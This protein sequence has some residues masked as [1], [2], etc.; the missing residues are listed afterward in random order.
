MVYL[1]LK[2][3]F[4][5]LI[6]QKKKM[7]SNKFNLEINFRYVINQKKKTL[8][9]NSNLKVKFRYKMYKTCLYLHSQ[10]QKRWGLSL[11]TEDVKSLS[12]SVS[13]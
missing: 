3:K 2:D 6:R 12:F 10:P 7:F 11:V 8:K 4:R 13:P 5:G 9:A 1:N